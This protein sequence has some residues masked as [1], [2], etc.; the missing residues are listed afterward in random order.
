MIDD[1]FNRY[2]NITVELYNKLPDKLLDEI[3]PLLSCI[4]TIKAQRAFTILNRNGFDCHDLQKT[5]LALVKQL[6]GRGD[7]EPWKK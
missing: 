3:I 5:F 6:S 2:T 1:V 4:D 7:I